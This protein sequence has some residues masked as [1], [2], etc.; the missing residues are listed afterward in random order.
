ML[1]QDIRNFED[2]HVIFA[3]FVAACV[4]DTAGLFVW[5]QYPKEASI[6]KWYDRFGLV[7]YMLDVTSI[8]IGILLA[9]VAY[10]FVSKSW[11]PALFCAIAI[12]IQQ[13]HDL[14]F[15]QLLVPNVQKNHIFDVMKTYVGNSES[16]K[17]L[18]VDAVYMV[19]ASL[20]TMYLAGEKTWVSA[21]LL[22][23]TLYVTGY[24]L[25]IHA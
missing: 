13:V 15:S 25:Y 12:V 4:V 2:I 9:Q 20:L 18:I 23:T 11:S 19:L 24:A 16:W 21:S 5:R 8:V 1:L 10:G 7:A 3:A 14:A 17:V 22:V 6:S